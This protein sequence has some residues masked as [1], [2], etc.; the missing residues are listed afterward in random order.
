MHQ[1]VPKD[2]VGAD[3]HESRVRD[4]ADSVLKGKQQLPESGTLAVTKFQMVSVI[5][6]KRREE[7]EKW[8]LNFQLDNFADM[9]KLEADLRDMMQELT[10]IALE[11]GQATAT[12]DTVEF[13]VAFAT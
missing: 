9:D 6:Y 4:F 13:D 1:G 10:E 8:L 12:E 11:E 3:I 7:Q 2:F 5:F